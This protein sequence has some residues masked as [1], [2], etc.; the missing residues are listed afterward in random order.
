ML[1]L[2]Y[3]GIVFSVWSIAR[4]STIS[5]GTAQQGMSMSVMD[6]V[7]YITDFN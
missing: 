7:A 1:Y 6:E 2:D 3:L 5:N 4:L